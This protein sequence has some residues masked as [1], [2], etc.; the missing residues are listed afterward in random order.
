MVSAAS[1]AKVFT[2]LVALQLWEGGYFALGDDVN[3][4]LRRF[5]V[6]DFEGHVLTIWHLLTHT[7]GFKARI[8]G[9]GIRPDEPFPELREAAR[10]YMPRRILPPGK[11]ITY[12]SYASN[13]L[14]VLIEDISG[15]PFEEYVKEHILKPLKMHHTTFRRPLPEDLLEGL[16]PGCEL[17]EGKFTALPF[18]ASRMAPQGGTLHDCCRHGTLCASTP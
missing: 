11:Q 17:R 10:E 3:Q 2:A 13:L 7:D 12:G 16:A 5:K 8:T 15:K 6:P 18:V 9:D 14:G 1:V 4:R